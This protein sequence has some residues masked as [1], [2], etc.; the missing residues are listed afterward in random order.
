VVIVPRHSSHTSPCQPLLRGFTERSEFCAYHPTAA[1]PGADPQFREHHKPKAPGGAGDP[2]PGT[3]RASKRGRAGSLGRTAH[4]A[5][6]SQA[7]ARAMGDY[8][9]RPALSTAAVP[10]RPH[11]DHHNGSGGGAD[12]E[13]APRRNID[14]SARA[15]APVA[16]SDR[17]RAGQVDHRS[18][19]AG[20]GDSRLGLPAPAADLRGARHR[21]GH[22]RRAAAE[23]AEAG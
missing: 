13:A 22:P 5:I 14:Q 10:G 18:G 19:G 9:P 8:G 1:A 23:G 2:C 12:S 20:W 7:G 17:E 21:G 15:R 6:G 11:A 4:V 3:C 16:A